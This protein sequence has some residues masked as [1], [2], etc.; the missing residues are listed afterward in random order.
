MTKH[1][2]IGISG[3]I[4]VA[5]L[6]I[7]IVGPVSA[8]AG[9]NPVIIVTRDKNS[10]TE[11]N[12][13]MVYL[14]GAYVGSTSSAYSNGTLVIPQ[15]S[16]GRH[17]VRIFVPGYHQVTK[18]FVYPET[19]TVEILLQKEFLVSLNPSGISTRAIDV[20]YYPSTVSY[21]CNTH[22]PVSTPAYILNETQ[23]RTDVIDNINQTYLNLD[24]ITDPSDPLP[25]NY[26]DKFN[27]YY[28][29]DPSSPANAFSG[30][31]GSIPENYW[32]EIPFSD[33][34]VILY[35]AYY[36]VYADSS[37]EMTGCTEFGPGH[38]QMK[39]PANLPILGTHETG[40]AVYGLVD[41]YCGDTYYIQ[42]DPHPNVWS[43]QEACIADARSRYRDPE[44]CRQIQSSEYRTSNTCVK[45]FWKFDLTPDIMYSGYSGTFGASST[46]RIKYILSQAGGRQS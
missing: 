6:V 14:D 37:C 1:A 24:K 45:N 13:A 3:W 7:F 31:A 38:N 33:V 12:D 46:E 5:M 19:S 11:L 44:Q 39:T 30:C 42:N 29:Y 40:H 10:K 34:I 4:L 35:P 43:S 41:T 22:T 15:V 27:F 17:T 20:V 8:A 23:F 25:Q 16:D 32:N 18:P 28:Y 21:D 2:V 26:Q 9:D 36:G